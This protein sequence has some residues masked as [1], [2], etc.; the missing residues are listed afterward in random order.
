MLSLQAGAKGLSCIQ[1]NLF[2]ELIVWLCAH[3]RDI[4]KKS[5]VDEVQAFF[6]NNMDPMHAAYPTAAKYVL[7]QNGFPIDL[8]TRR[9]VGTLTTEHKVELD[10]LRKEGE[11]LL[12]KTRQ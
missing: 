7:Q 8:Y 1:G 3:A 6:A 9:D 10:R 2:P 12:L 11:A 4:A 5:V